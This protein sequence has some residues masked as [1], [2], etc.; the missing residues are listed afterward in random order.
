MVNPENDDERVNVV[1]T[2]AETRYFDSGNSR[3]CIL[4]ST[5]RSDLQVGTQ[6]VHDNVPFSD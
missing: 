6:A 5:P 2:H 4:P 3:L 1:R